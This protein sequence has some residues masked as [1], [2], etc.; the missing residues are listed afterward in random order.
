VIGR[1]GVLI[2]GDDGANREMIDEILSQPRQQ[3]LKPS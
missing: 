3:H 1:P 2:V